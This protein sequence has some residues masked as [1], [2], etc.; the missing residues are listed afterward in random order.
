MNGNDSKII[1]FLQHQRLQALKLS[2]ETADA[3]IMHLVNR[4]Y[5]DQNPEAFY[6]E[7]EAIIDILNELS[8]NLHACDHFANSEMALLNSKIGESMDKIV[9]ITSQLY[10]ECDAMLSIDHAQTKV[11]LVYQIANEN[12]FKDT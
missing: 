8:S 10:D 7:L 3:K 12:T 5:T 2:I 4:Y 11:L 9:T 6:N 1:N